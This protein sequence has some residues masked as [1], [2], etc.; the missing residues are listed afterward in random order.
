MRGELNNANEPGGPLFTVR[1]VGETLV[2]SLMRRCNV[3]SWAPLHGGFR[4]D[5]A[6]LLVHSVGDTEALRSRGSR[7]RQAVGRV[8]LKGTVVGMMTTGDPIHYSIGNA[9]EGDLSVCAISVLDD[10]KVSELRRVGGHDS[11]A[12]AGSTCLVLFL[13][14]HLSHEAMLEATS[15]A[16]EVKVRALVQQEAKGAE[17]SQRL[18]ANSMDCV[19]VAA[20]DHRHRH[21]TG[22][23]A[24]LVRLIA[25]ACRE[26]LRAGESNSIAKATQAG[27]RGSS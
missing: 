21:Y 18:G 7:L 11:P 8:G 24:A 26:S 25:S 23:H 20:E 9:A 6:H 14:Q 2:L 5:V 10:R 1:A 12:L 19:A 16:T 4:S 17:A 3:V 27:V 15:I 13:N 22:S